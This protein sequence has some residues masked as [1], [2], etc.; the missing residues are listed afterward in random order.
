MTRPNLE[1]LIAMRL[2]GKEVNTVRLEGKLYLPFNEIVMVH[3]L[4]TRRVSA[5]FNQRYENKRVRVHEVDDL[6]RMTNTSGPYI[7]CGLEGFLFVQ[8]Q[9]V[10]PPTYTGRARLF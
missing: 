7:S 2:K 5:E 10:E 9:P 4:D 1:D 3:R 8:E 6:S